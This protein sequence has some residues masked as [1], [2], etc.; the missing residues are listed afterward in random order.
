[1][2]VCDNNKKIAS[3]SDDRDW[4]YSLKNDKAEL[5]S[6][7]T[8]K[9]YK[10]AV[11]NGADAVYF[12]YGKF[13][14]R[15]DGDNFTELSSAVEYCHIYNVKAYLALNII[16]KNSELS[17]VT[18]IIKEAESA[19]I[20]AFIITDLALVKIIKKYSKA[21]IH[22]STQ[23]GIH[24]IDGVKF[25][26]R[27]G[28]DRVILSRE[29][30]KDDINAILKNSNM[31]LEIFVHG[32]LCVAF[33]GACLMSSM[34]MGM[35]GNRG[36][37]NQLC[38]KQYTSY[39]DMKPLQTGYL[40]SAKDINMLPKIEELCASGIKSLKIEG[41]LKRAEYIAGVTSIYRKYIDKQHNIKSQD[42]N[43]L[44]LLYNRGNFCQGY[45]DG[46]DIIYSPTGS[47]IGIKCGV[48]IKIME[49][50]KV[51]IKTEIPLNKGDGIKILRNKREIGGGTVI[52]VEN[53]I[54]QVHTS[55]VVKVGDMASLTTDT[56]L[57][58]IIL[59][60]DKKLHAEAA[61]RLVGGEKAHIILSGGGQIVDFYSD[62]IIE[63]ADSAPLTEKNIKEQ[64]SK[65]NNT[66]FEM[67]YVKVI[68]ENAFIR[69][70]DLNE[71]RRT[72]LVD[73]YNKIKENYQRDLSDKNIKTIR[74]SEK[75]EGDFAE[76]DTVAKL[77]PIITTYI[78][79]IVYNPTILDFE[80]AQGFYEKAKA[81]SNNV[82]IKPPIFV[83]NKNA[84][85]LSQIMQIFD[86][87]VANNLGYLEW[88][89]LHNKKIV[90]GYNLNI[91]NSKNPLKDICGQYF[92]SVEANKGQL[93]VFKGAL[94]YTYGK[95][96]L[97]YLQFCP[98][99]NS[100]IKCGDCR[101]SFYFVDEH[102]DYPV[103][104]QYFDGTCNHTLKNGIITSIGG[105]FD[106]YAKYFDFTEAKKSEIENVMFDYYIR[107]NFSSDNYNRLH[108]NRGV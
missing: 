14:A 96:P 7:A 68:T 89:L 24:S 85:K 10:Y 30:N 36:K 57:N 54:A 18:E 16:F 33:S 2:Y 71:L 29:V 26:E 5:L 105:G 102:S 94:I 8:V 79:N 40:L 50:N 25:L 43:S 35:S 81:K 106:E 63:K 76:I 15:A 98:K 56:A 49:P 65:T 69:K 44:K 46:N 58:K 108:L 19:G 88:A 1:M 41:R 23:M 51:F 77:Y 83:H 78:P 17:I 3:Y 104:T 90:G 95:L 66:V 22:A 72:L 42:I 92:I 75:I 82:F 55:D 80:N 21:Q 37:C 86:G 12:G 48:V 84:E 101:K 13:N 60:N 4:I 32:A 47:H 93:K 59:E 45:F 97:M 87:V 67:N 52:S 99:K 6:P 9:T 20:D 103:K 70:G 38:R 91:L 34:L 28:I 31:D 39:Y 27:F 64:F 100:G 74:K 107:K 73:L 62:N 11:K 53:L 61:I